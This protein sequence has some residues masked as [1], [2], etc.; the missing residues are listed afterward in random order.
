MSTWSN[1]LS[2]N[3][4]NKLVIIKKEYKYELASH[5]ERNNTKIALPSWPDKA[6]P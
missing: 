2:K 6:V 5:G 3:I 1:L 4:E